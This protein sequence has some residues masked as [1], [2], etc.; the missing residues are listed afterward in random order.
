MRVWR[1]IVAG[2]N[3][4]P[5]VTIKRIRRKPIPSGDLSTM[6]YRMVLQYDKK[7]QVLVKK[8]TRRISNVAVLTLN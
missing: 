4:N 5:V 2:I 3:L 1:V 6:M 8:I 7:F